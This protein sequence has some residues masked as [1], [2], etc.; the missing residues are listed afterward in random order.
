MNSINT[1]QVQWLESR[2]E[3]LAQENF[4]LRA[5]FDSAELRSQ[6]SVRT[7]KL[8]LETTL[9]NQTK[10]TRENVNRLEA[11]TAAKQ[12]DESRSIQERLNQLQN[13]MDRIAVSS[14]AAENSSAKS[15]GEVLNLIKAE[16]KWLERQKTKL[17]QERQDHRQL[18]LEI[19]EQLRRMDALSAVR[20][21]FTQNN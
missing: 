17:K 16:F 18:Q 1:L 6:E 5:R 13:Q 12:A 3:G 20:I 14:T 9:E 19:R 15:A 4:A 11:A 10:W 21:F 7:I 8:E 2:I